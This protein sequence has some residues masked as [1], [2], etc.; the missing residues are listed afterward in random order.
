MSRT[1]DEKVVEMRF[2]NSNFERNVSTTMSTLDRL[3]QKLNL[4]GASKGLENI[5]SAARNVNMSGLG[6]AVES[7]RARFSALEVMGVTALANITNSAVNAGKR[8]VSS[9]TIDQ[10]TAG[11]NK[12]GEKTA[13]VQAILNATG[14][15][16]DEVNGYLDQLM[17]YSDETSY[18][19]TDMTTSLGQLASAG[20]D[21]EKLIPMIEGVA[22]ATAFAGKGAT[23]FSR[24]IYNLN[25][26][27]SA[28]YLQYMDW[29]SLELAGVAS[30]QLKETLIDT[31]VAMGKIKEGEVTIA[32]FSE[33]LKDKWADTSV[34]EAAF[35]KFSEMTQAAYEAVKSGEYETASEAIDALASKYDELGVKAFR[36][37]QEAK[38]F[39]EAID[40]TKDAVSTGWMRTSELIFGNYEESRKLWTDVANSFWDI[41]ASGGESRNDML[42]TAMNSKWDQLIEQIE[43]A[44][45]SAE[46]FQD[47]LKETAREQGVAIDDLIAEY[48]SLGRVISAGKLSKGVI[49]ETIKKLAGYFDK[50]SSAVE[51]TT[52]KLEH[53]QSL[54]TRVIRGDFGNGVDRV[55]AMA[56]AGENYAAVQTLVN[57]VWERTGGTWSDCTVTADDLASVINDLSDSE[58]ESMGYTEE[59]VKALRELAKQAEETGTP[60]NEL[61]QSLEKPSGRELLVGTIHNVLEAISKALASIREGWSEIFTSDRVANGVYRFLEILNNLS[62]KLILSDDN[63]DKLR[64]TVKGIAAAFDILLTVIGGPIKIAFNFIKEVLS[65]LNINILDVTAAVGDAIVKFR[66]WI[67]EHDYIAEA[68]KKLAPYIT[69]LVDWIGKIIDGIGKWISENEFLSKAIDKVSKFIT[70][71]IDAI[72]AWVDGLKETDNVG[73]YIVEGLLKGIWEGIKSVGAAMW[74]FAQTIISTVCEVLGI[75]SPST[76]FFG[77]GQNVI[78]G[79]INGLKTGFTNVWTWLEGFGEKLVDRFVAVVS[80]IDFSMVFGVGVLGLVYY[81]IKKFSDV[82]NALAAPLQG[83]KNMYTGIGNMFTG[84]GKF[85]EGAAWNQR[86]K[87]ARTFAM[88]IAILA[89]SVMLLAQIPSESLWRSVGAIG[90]LAGILTA[91]M[92]AMTGLEILMNKFGG[93]LGGGSKDTATALLMLSGSLLII[94]FAMQKLSDIDPDKMPAIV[95]SLTAAVI[96]LGVLMAAC[97]QLVKMDKGSAA[98]AGLSVM[99]MAASMLIMV[100]VIKKLA[101]VSDE[102]VMKGVAFVLA[103]GLLFT[104]ITAV[105]SLANNY[106]AGAGAMLLL[107]SVAM[108][109]MVK[110]VKSAAKLN[111]SDA[112]R[113]LMFV[114]AVGALFTAIIAVSYVAGE[115][116]ARAGAALLLMAIAMRLM[117]SVVHAAGSMDEN[118]LKRGAAFVA[119]IGALFAAIIAVSH[120]A[121]AN[122]AKAGTMLL[123]MAAAIGILSLSMLLLSSLDDQAVARGLAAIMTMLSGFAVIVG[124]T[125]KA[126]DVSKTMLPIVIGIGLLTLAVAGLSF[127]DPARLAVATASLS[128][129]MGMFAVMVAATRFAKNSKAMLKTISLMSGVVIVL[130]GLVLA[131]STI[132][133][134]SSI[135]PAVAGLSALML[136]FSASLVIL[137]QAGRISKTVRKTLYPMVGVLAILGG[138]LAVLAALDTGWNAIQSA[139]GLGI[140]INA[141]AASL[142]IL[143]KV[144]TISKSA[145]D[146]LKP[147][148]LVSAG[149]GAVLMFLAGLE[150]GNNAIQSAIGLGILLNAFSASLLILSKVKTI[151]KSAKDALE[152]MTEVAIK[153]GIILGVLSILPAGNGVIQSAV[154][155]GILLNAFST[156]LLILS[157]AKSISKSAKDALEPM[158]EVAMKLGLILGLLAILPAGNGAIQSAIGL[159]ILLNAFSASLLIL[160]KVKT[161]SK[162]AKDALEPMLGITLGLAVILGVLAAFKMDLSIKSALALGVLL[163]AMAAALVIL[164]FVK[165]PATEGVTAMMLLGIVVLELG[166]VLS[167]IAKMDVESCIPMAVALSTLLVAMSASLILLGV[168]GMMGPAAFIGIAALG[169]MILMLGGIFEAIGALTTWFPKLEQFLDKG[170]AI[171]DKIGHAIG[172][173]FGNIVSGFTDAVA[174]TLP[175]IGLALTQFMANATPFIVG[176]KMVDGTVL[177]GVQTLAKSVLYLAGAD[178][179]SRIPKLVGSEA[180][181]ADLGTVL[182][183]FMENASTFIEKAADIDPSAMRGVKTLAEAVTIFTAGDFIEGLKNKIFGDSGGLADFSEQL[184]AFGEGIAAFSAAV[185]GNID[186]DAVQAAAS[187]GKVMAEL[188]NNLP[189]DPDSVIGKLTGKITMDEFGDQLVPFGKAMVRFSETVAGNI[190]ASAVEAASTAGSLMAE[191]ANKLPDSPD[192]VMGKIKGKIPMDEFGDQLVLFGTAMVR[193]SEV[194][195][196]NISTDAVQ[197]AATAGGIMSELANGLPEDPGS[198]KAWFTGA[199][200]SLTDF[201]QELMHF[202]SAIVSFSSIVAGNIDSA[203]VESAANAGSMMSALAKNLPEEKQWWKFWEKDTMDFSGFA[204]ELVEFAKGMAEFSKTLTEAGVNASLISTVTEVGTQIAKLD[205]TLPDEM[206]LSRIT[207]GLDTFGQAM[208]DFS[209]KI[210]GNVDLA[211]ISVCSEVGKNLS[212]TA[213]LMPDEVDLSRITNGLDEFGAALVSFSTTVKD[214]NTGDSLTAA[215]DLGKS[216][217]EMVSN[218]PEN[219]DL[220]SYA[221]GIRKLGEALVAFSST[222]GIGS[223]DQT[224]VSTACAAGVQI[225]QMMYELPLTINPEN[226]INNVADVGKALVDFSTAVAEGFDMVTITEATDAGS[227]IA[228]MLKEIPN[229]VDPTFF[230]DNIAKVGKALGDFS[231]AVDGT[232][233]RGAIDIAADCGNDIA[234]TLTNLKGIPDISEFVTN[235][236]SFGQALVDY[237]N[238]V[239]GNI[240]SSSVSEANLVISSVGSTIRN[241]P[242]STKLTAVITNLPKF[243]ESLE[244]F[245]SSVNSI[246]SMSISATVGRVRNAL[247]SLNSKITSFNIA[248]LSDVTDGFTNFNTALKDLGVDSITSFVRELDNAKS[249]VSTAGSNLVKGLQDGLVSGSSHLRTACIS[250][251]RSCTSSISNRYNDFVNLGRYLV[252]GFAQGITSNTYLAQARARDMAWAAYG[253]A[254]RRLNVNSPSKVFRKL[255]TAVP[256]GFAQGIGKLGSLVEGSAVGMADTAI[257]GTRNAIARISDII[258]SD[259]DAQPTIRP[260]LDLSEIEAGAGAIN[261]MVGGTASIGVMSNIN[262]ISTMMNRRQNGSSNDVIS[263]IKDLGRTLGNA[264]GNTYTING[265]TYDDGSNVSEAIRTL[266]RAAKVE[267]RM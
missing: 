65:A 67:K 16:L 242:E 180:S 239:D 127:I 4:S 74:E 18:G 31:A 129:L 251:V 145:K 96:A 231:A 162:S 109:I 38:S 257:D 225:G 5:D 173:F 95:E 53:F 154:G 197:T 138:V 105:A 126:K 222:D 181:L 244:S 264:S 205:K 150:T 206:D 202:G 89:G 189:P 243:G 64:R 63:A 30:K 262:A 213:S 238:K 9:L 153:L 232:I 60:L 218:V 90:A 223:I 91:F 121:G 156:S 227:R 69:K 163:N 125:H 100:R 48:G 174:S 259:V 93:G 220:V 29:R 86:A 266:V 166:V 221:A 209:A 168:A 199:N 44:G 160:S 185:A 72:S 263:A 46:T 58:I 234:E 85:F 195:A 255:G 82:V 133:D 20:G 188:A 246:N 151:S 217:K 35:G 230:I 146:A 194:V 112:A 10:V 157:K 182:S 142:L 190:D 99:L 40:A 119:G 144:K 186:A 108:L 2:D 33:T 118:E 143:S 98:A 7:V 61:I 34:M 192:T 41:F 187:A 66:D 97:G 6:N 111:P 229:N 26:S 198:I 140:I 211:A 13:S 27:Y 175:T 179:I 201:G 148:L 253:A 236:T 134:P 110:V 8:I 43:A 235:L 70:T 254:K 214:I 241:F 219:V 54:V 216:I 116:S 88:A 261:S 77:I 240:N 107:M 19:F 245:S 73:E 50:T 203:A 233:N 210:S 49:I 141:F 104:T 56:A 147:M 149:L 117:V 24:A 258:N 84:I 80:K 15:S 132:K 161:V 23:E 265:I 204:T 22:N 59:Q 212:L 55:N 115:Y 249:T 87:A 200:I 92:G 183:K 123:A 165:A 71:S 36:S 130:A 113:G 228:T 260:V 51:V 159:G 120:F 237:S 137:G 47:K 136:A 32:N 167:M 135:L 76:V 102:D 172:S 124:M 224:A 193:F 83:L 131:L 196:G 139:V 252:Q 191:L 37:A 21:I 178:F 39:S 226:F 14:K 101:G 122:A 128:A 28:G 155:L 208:I 152:P 94:A 248:A 250:L 267:R 177:T 81:G 170:I 42:S 215:V 169:T 62:S 176:M 256:E 171:M 3:K 52:D 207:T 78:A 25:Q 164:Q 114:T 158:A 17:W 247:E 68:A 103:V 11:W 75:H 1:I 57:K 79:F 12:Y 45:V 184:V 106:S